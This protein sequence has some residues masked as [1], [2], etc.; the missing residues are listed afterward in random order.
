MINGDDRRNDEYRRD[1]RYWDYD[2][3]DA[4]Q[5][6]QS[7]LCPPQVERAVVCIQEGLRGGEFAQREARQETKRRHYDLEPVNDDGSI[8]ELLI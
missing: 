7:G 1:N 4:T 6:S 3:W 8:A 5:S 2:S